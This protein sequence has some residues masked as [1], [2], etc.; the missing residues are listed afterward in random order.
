M[1]KTNEGSVDRILRIVVGLALLVWFFVD[2]GQGFWH[3]AK[4]IGI[5]P[6]ATGLIGW[7]PLY[8]ILGVSTCPMKKA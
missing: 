4:L 8:T 1:F 6:L 2:Q 5:V 7:C 3:Y